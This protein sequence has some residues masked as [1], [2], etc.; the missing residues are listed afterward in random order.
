MIDPITSSNEYNVKFP[1]T[2][3]KAIQHLAA[4]KTENIQNL[5]NKARNQIYNKT[6]QHLSVRLRLIF[7][8]CPQ[9]FSKE[10]YEIN[11]ISKENNLFK[12]CLFHQ[13]S[14]TRVDNFYRKLRYI[15]YAVTMYYIQH[16]NS[17]LSSDD[18]PEK[19]LKNDKNTTISLEAFFNGVDIINDIITVPISNNSDEN[20]LNYITFLSKEDIVNLINICENLV[21]TI[22]DYIT[23]EVISPQKIR[24]LL[25]NI[26]EYY[27]ECKYTYLFEQLYTSP[28]KEK[29]KNEFSD[30]DTFCED[31]DTLAK[32]YHRAYTYISDT[33][34]QFNFQ[35][36]KAL[37]P[38]WDNTSNTETE[39]SQLEFDFF[40]YL[41]HNIPPRI[42]G[43]KGN[44]LVSFSAIFEIV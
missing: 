27:T 35:K 6:W 8:N 29:L 16:K 22:Y 3:S 33:V 25:S 28:I 32:T 9:N 14:E 21:L 31:F 2:L 40:S 5:D 15:Y 4:L 37:L 38:T 1:L 30:Y 11:Y 10:T 26:E 17:P 19:W 24:W 12:T 13:L 39:V 23:K 20:E 34:W 18:V 42:K 44:I 36:S 43:E 7:K 41:L